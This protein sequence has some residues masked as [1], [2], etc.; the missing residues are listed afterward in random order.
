MTVMINFLFI[1]V[2]VN[3]AKHE[4]CCFLDVGNTI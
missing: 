3:N 1:D 4:V 2:H